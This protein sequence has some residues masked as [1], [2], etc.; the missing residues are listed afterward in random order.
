MKDRLHCDSEGF[1]NTL[2]C[3]A[4]AEERRQRAARTAATRADLGRLILR[5]DSGTSWGQGRL[6]SLSTEPGTPPGH[7]L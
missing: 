2:R 6:A 1:G 4:E 3:W 5:R 7:H